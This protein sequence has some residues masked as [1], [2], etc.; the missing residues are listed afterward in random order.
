MCMRFPRP[1]TESTATWRWVVLVSFVW[2][3]TLGGCSS[4]PAPTD[5]TRSP[6]GAPSAARPVHPDPW[7]RDI[8][9]ASQLQF[10]HRVGAFAEYEMPAIMGSGGGLVDFDRDGRLDAYLVNGARA[11]LQEQVEEEL[12]GADAL[13]RQ[14]AALRFANVTS[15]LRV[16]PHGFGMGAWW[17]DVDDDGFPDL[18][19]TNVGRNQLFH[20]LG[21][22]TFEEIPLPT[23]VAPQAWSTAAS[24]ADLNGDG[25]LD[26]FVVNYV[27]YVPGQFCEGPDGRREFC[28]P[29]A[30]PGTV[31]RLL[32]NFGQF[33]AEG[34]C[35]ADETVLRGL[36]DLAGKGLG[37]LARDFDGD[38]RIDLYVAND[39][40]SN[41]LWMQQEDGTFAE[42]AVL[43]GLARNFLG[44]AEASMGVVTGDWNDDGL[45]DLFV[46]HLAGETNTYYLS[47]GSGSW[48]DATAVAQLG[49]P[50]LPFTGFGI[51]AC[52]FEHDGDIDFL[53][54]NGGVK[55]VSSAHEVRPEDAYTQPNSL[56]RC[57]DAAALRFEAA[58]DLGGEFTETEEISRAL[59]MG[60]LDH[61]GDVDVLECNCAGAARLL[62]NVAQKEGHWL[63][64]KL[65]DRMGTRSALGARVWVTL[66]DGTRIERFMNP[67]LGYLTQNDEWLHFGLG[68][69]ETF[70][71]LEVE[72]PD[73][74]REL[75][76]GGIVD[77]RL[78]VV[79]GGEALEIGSTRPVLEGNE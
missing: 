30:Y 49:P 24:W 60:D 50:S 51:A 11:T 10:V 6:A 33:T 58:N 79:R 4:S 35:F 77:R 32:I 54:A 5:S 46:T 27:D 67:Y 28:G 62:E 70:E 65:L 26:L 63:A 3:F 1:I 76:A 17:G 13:F 74:D 37:T 68:Q 2:L 21:D 73:G 34:T 22:G 57:V 14:V 12:R 66:G 23:G 48:R 40:E 52:D 47:E 15:R 18:F 42:Q 36:G 71:S 53:I 9:S 16:E 43:R 20:N 29:S 8:T 38:G 75:F 59:A 78:L 41:Y 25:L 39:M 31:D 7:L 64:V 61:D 45:P 56:Y 55:R 69:V 44:E 19:L 72:W